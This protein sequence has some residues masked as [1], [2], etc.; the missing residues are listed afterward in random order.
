MA[1]F[2]AA[3]L[4]IEVGIWFLMKRLGCGLV[5]GGGG[6]WWLTVVADGGCGGGGW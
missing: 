1:V 4:R 6:W 5:V 2:R 3:L